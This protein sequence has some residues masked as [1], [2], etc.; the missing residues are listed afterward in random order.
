[1]SKRIKHETGSGNVFADLGLPDPEER[2]AKAEI[3]FRI[4]EQAF[5]YLDAPIK[6]MG[7]FDVPVPFTPPL[8]LV[9]IPDKER[10]V[11]AVHQ[12]SGK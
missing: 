10:I 4:Y 9:T 2:L 12:L 7:A 3:A 5:D 1:M 6:R 11:E 8:E